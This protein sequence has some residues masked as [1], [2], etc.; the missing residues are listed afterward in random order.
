MP[1]LRPHHDGKAGGTVHSVA[2]TVEFVELGIIG[3]A[4][5][6]HVG[7][8]SDGAWL[9]RDASEVDAHDNAHDQSWSPISYHRPL[10]T[11]KEV[12]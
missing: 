5:D 4:E 8:M 10:T 12:I 7:T 6:P 2:G 9:S 11:L 1:S 3:G